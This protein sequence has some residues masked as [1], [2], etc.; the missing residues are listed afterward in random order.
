MNLSDSEFKRI[1]AENAEGQ[2]SKTIEELRETLKLKER[3]VTEL[4][5]MKSE[6]WQQIQDMREKIKVLQ[7]GRP[8][9]GRVQVKG[10]SVDQGKLVSLHAKNVTLEKML[11]GFMRALKNIRYG[12]AMDMTVGG[13]Y[14]RTKTSLDLC[15]HL[16]MDTPQL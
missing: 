2:Q 1:E 14:Q 15:S 6:Y 4:R 9:L 11:E 8:G 5:T 13:A 3:L 16:S 10:T 7:S 12:D